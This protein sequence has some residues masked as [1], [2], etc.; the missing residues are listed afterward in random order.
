MRFMLF[1]FLTVMKLRDFLMR[2][3]AFFGR[4]EI[5]L[6]GHTLLAAELKMRVREGE[7]VD[8]NM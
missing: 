6:R 1:V 3:H 5:F 7:G 2:F 8:G 4:Y